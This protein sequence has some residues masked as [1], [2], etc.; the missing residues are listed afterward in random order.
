MMSDIHISVAANSVGIESPKGHHYTGQSLQLK[1]WTHLNDSIDTSVQIIHTWTGPSGT[2]TTDSRKQVT[3]ISKTQGAYLSSL[4][5]HSLRT[6]DSGT[7]S[8]LS[9]IQPNE[10]YHVSSFISS[11]NPKIASIA[12]NAGKMNTMNRV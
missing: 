3:R 8:C 4:T 6:S 7:Y 11:S 1:C 10:N 5:F 2:I 9:T 12:V